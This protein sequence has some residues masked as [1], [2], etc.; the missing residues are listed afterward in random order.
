MVSSDN[1]VAFIIGLITGEGSFYITVSKEDRRRFG[2]GYGARF[3]MSMGQYSKLM[4]ERVRDS[5]GIGR[6]ASDLKGYDWII[7][8]REEC[9]ELSCLI[10]DHL[11]T[12]DSIF[13]STPKF[14]SY[15][16]WT[17]ALKILQ[18]GR[19]LTKQEIITLAHL[20]DEI[21]PIPGKG[22]SAEE[23]IDIINESE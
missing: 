4:L 6:V 8:S 23:I 18:P 16:K 17:Q 10:D 12:H 22:R 7:S 2:V 21:N 9:H 1:D 14:E 20:K 11:A 19:R 15:Q 3:R 5:V 13:T